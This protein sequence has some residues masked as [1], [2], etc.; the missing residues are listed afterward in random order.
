VEPAPASAAPP[1]EPDKPDGTVEGGRI[2]LRRTPFRLTPGLRQLLSYLL[3]HPG[4]PADD[5][6]R[7][8]GFSGSSHLHKRLKD[9]RDKLAAELKRSGWRLHIRTDEN[10]IYCEWREAR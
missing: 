8:C 3:A 1:D 9:L 6:G 2:W 4:A 10:R 7:H 5:V